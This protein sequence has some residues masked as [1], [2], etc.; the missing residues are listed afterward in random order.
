MPRAAGLGERVLRTPPL[1]LA[2]VTNS[3]R[4]Y[5]VRTYGCQMNEHDSERIAGLLDADG[6]TA[7]HDQADADV[8]VLNT[9]CIRE[10]AKGFLANNPEIMVEVSEKVRV[11]AGIGTDV[12]APVPAFSEADEQPIEI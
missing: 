11:Q 8:V 10:N 2:D 12:A 3:P 5:V 7:V 1:A 4:R 6:L 9:C